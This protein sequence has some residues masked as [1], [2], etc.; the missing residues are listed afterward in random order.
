MESIMRTNNKGIQYVLPVA[1]LLVIFFLVPLVNVIKMS[2]MEWAI[3]GES[4][5]VG[6]SNYLKTFQAKEFW[7]SMGNTT[8]YSLLVTPMIFFPAM[9]FCSLT[10]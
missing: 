4:T 6:L 7:A 3:L 8:I 5:F 9:L 2:M 1:V 10:Q